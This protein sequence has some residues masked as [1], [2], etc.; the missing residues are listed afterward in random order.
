MTSVLPRHLRFCFGASSVER[1]GGR[2]DVFC[3]RGLDMW[4]EGCDAIM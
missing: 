4:M 2:T 3:L 1:A